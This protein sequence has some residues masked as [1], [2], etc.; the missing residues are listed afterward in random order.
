[1]RRRLLPRRDEVPRRI[2]LPRSCMDWARAVGSEADDLFLQLA[3]VVGALSFN[4]RQ[5]GSRPEP[6][7]TRQRVIRVD[8]YDLRRGE[9]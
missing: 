1:M 8:D 2:P 7:K 4:A 5:M 9:R 3:P 6:I